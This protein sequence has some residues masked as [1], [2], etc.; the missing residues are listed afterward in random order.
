MTLIQKGGLCPLRL[1]P[2]ITEF[3]VYATSGYSTREQLDKGRFFEELQN[4]ENKNKVNE[5]KII[6]EDFN[7]TMNKI[8]RD[9]ENKT[10]SL[11]WR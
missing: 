9:G 7:C 10:K 4:M 5:N 2:L 1:L 11:F 3:C 8:D 6:T